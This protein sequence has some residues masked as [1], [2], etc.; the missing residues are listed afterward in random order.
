MTANIGKME[1]SVTE[2]DQGK[3]VD[4]F[5][6]SSAEEFSRSQIQKA[7]DDEQ[8]TVNGQLVKRNY[9]LKAGDIITFLEVEPEEINTLPENIPLDILF[10]D[11]DV[12]VVNK[13][14]G[15]VVHP[16]PGNLTGTLVNALLYHCKDLSG[17]NGKLRP[18]IVHRIDKDTSGILVAA[19]NDFSHRALAEQLKDHEM[20][21]GY[22]A[23][24]H[25]SLEHNA[26]TIDAPIGRSPEDR[27]KMAV[28]FEHS[29]N[30]V[31]Q[32]DVLER[33]PD[34]TL[35][36]LK[37]ETG[38]THQIRVHMAF[39]KH[40]VVGDPKYGPAKN[41]FD[42]NKQALHA[43]LL[44]F[45]HPRSEEYVEFTV[46]IPDYFTEILSALGSVKGVASNGTMEK[47]LHGEQPNGSRGTEKLS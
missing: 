16:A 14:Q 18:G 4:L 13:P 1:I 2:G 47:T 7:I 11:S 21:R 40:P 28:S 31:T 25:G 29:R 20:S 27:K 33:F 9:R 5:L 36:K 26:G 35:V 45:K 41:D 19:K 37:L 44:G 39:I 17:I 22:I 32:F 15:M 6:S 46:G 34:Y 8:V 30:A 43:Y 23:L 10:E 12:I 42:L 24:V 3:R 38:R